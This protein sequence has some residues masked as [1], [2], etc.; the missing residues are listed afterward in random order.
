MISWLW[1]L[2]VVS[3]ISERHTLI[4]NT[5]KIPNTHVIGY[6]NGPLA[7]MSFSFQMWWVSRHFGISHYHIGVLKPSNRTQASGQVFCVAATGKSHKSYNT[8]PP[9]YT[10]HHFETEM[11]TFLFQ[12]MYCGKWDRCTVWLVIL[13]NYTCMGKPGWLLSFLNFFPELSRQWLLISRS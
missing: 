7:T 1:N 13:V 5:N 12:V 6:W 11:C 8:P 10:T 9:N 4:L 3:R 2:T